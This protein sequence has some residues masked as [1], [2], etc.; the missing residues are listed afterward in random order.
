VNGEIGA[1]RIPTKNK[2]SYCKKNLLPLFE[3]YPKKKQ[4]N[5][6]S[7]YERKKQSDIS[8]ISVC[9]WRNSICKRS[10]KQNAET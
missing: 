6:E 4:Y 5:I 10:N 2:N 1:Y 7:K 3:D 8:D 9:K